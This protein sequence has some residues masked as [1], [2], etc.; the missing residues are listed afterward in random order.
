[1]SQHLADNPH[2]WRR[3]P[4]EMRALAE[5]V[6]DARTRE[7]TIRMADDCRRLSQRVERVERIWPKLTTRGPAKKDNVI[8]ASIHECD[9]DIGR[10]DD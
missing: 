1:M 7:I 6:S 2:H 5:Q 8:H 9:A 3:R 10:D 4:D